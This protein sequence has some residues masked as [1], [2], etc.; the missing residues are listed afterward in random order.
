MRDQVGPE[1]AVHR[2]PDQ[3]HVEEPGGLV[4]R[5]VRGDRRD[6]LRRG[7][8]PPL[9]GEVPVGLHRQQDALGPAGADRADHRP[10]RR[11]MACRAEHGR[12]HRDDLRLELRGAGPQVRVQRV[13]L[14]LGRVDAV[15][16]GHV[17]RVA[18]VDGPGG[19][20]RPATRVPR[21][22]PAARP[23]RSPRPG[24]GRRPA[25]AVNEGTCAP[26]GLELAFQLGHRVGLGCPVSGPPGW[27]RGGQPRGRQPVASASPARQTTRGRR[28]TGTGS[29]SPP[30]RSAPG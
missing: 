20:A 27:H 29:R 3:R 5:R 18:V 7:D 8:A 10:F 4:E 24:P 16:E 1:P 19:V 15:E 26:V 2:D 17:L 6:D 13:A 30:G 23:G 12:G 9:A 28:G 11:G 14:R 21:S 22:R 25:A